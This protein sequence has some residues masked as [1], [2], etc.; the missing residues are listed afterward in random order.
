MKSLLMVLCLGFVMFGQ[1]AKACSCSYNS[2]ILDPEEG[3][4][5]V[6]R[7][8]AALGRGGKVDTNAIEQVDSYP[9]LEDKIAMI[10]LKGTTCEIK[11]P[12]GKSHNLCT[13]SYKADY[14]VVVAN[15]KEKCTIIVRAK[16]T[17]SSVKVRALSKSCE[18]I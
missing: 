11:G 4:V 18:T 17:R 3:I 6:A 13:S 1:E 5:N 7:I 10:E 8:K 12:T 14:K 9:S 15:S 2:A 16:T